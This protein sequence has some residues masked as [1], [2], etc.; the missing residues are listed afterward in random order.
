VLVVDDHADTL[1]LVSTVLRDHGAEVVAVSSMA[2][3]QRVFGDV[4]PHVLLSDIGMPEQDGYELIRFVRKLPEERGG[5]VPAAA[6]T[7]YASPADRRKI[8]DAGFQ[9]HIPKPVEPLA[10]I[11]LVAQLGGAARAAR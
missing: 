2:A 8:L 4:R 9:A 1:E 7:A 10:L 5:K 11:T 3:A 6:L